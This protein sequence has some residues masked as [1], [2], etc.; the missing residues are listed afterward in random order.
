L[1]GALNAQQFSA[2]V[3]NSG[4][5]FTREGLFFSSA[6]SSIVVGAGTY[7][8][9]TATYNAT[10]T[11]SNYTRAIVPTLIGANNIAGLR[12]TLA[13][14]PGIICP[15]TKY[16]RGGGKGTFMFSLPAYLSTQFFYYGYHD[17]ASA[18]YTTP[19]TFFNASNSVG[20]GKDVTDTELQFMWSSSF[21]AGVQKV[22]TGIIPNSEDVYR[23][24]VYVSPRPEYYI[25]LE[26]I[27]NNAPTVVRIYK[28][29][30][31]DANKPIAPKLMFAYFIGNGAAGG[32]IS[33]GLIKLT[34]EI[35]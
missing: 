25:Q 21:P 20:I 11:Q 27:N 22:S 31:T 29:G 5:T 14:P 6:N 9:T 12:T 13:Q 32:V 2:V 10:N 19:S 8:L 24:T 30:F 3:P 18:S 15:T 7:S 1:Q 17:N 4:A 34:E 16:G 35:Y 26:V 28:V 23:I 33:Y